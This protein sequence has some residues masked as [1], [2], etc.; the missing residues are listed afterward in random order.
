MTRFKKGNIVFFLDQNSYDHFTPLKARI[1]DVN[2]CFYKLEGYKDL[3]GNLKE[4][5]EGTLHTEE[6]ILE[7][8]KQWIKWI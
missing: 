1:I 7:E 6:E 8:F 2:G 5:T 4:V 3:W